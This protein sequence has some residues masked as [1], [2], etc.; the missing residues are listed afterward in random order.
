MVNHSHDRA[1]N[2]QLA[3]VVESFARAGSQRHV[4][5]ILKGIQLFR[6]D[7]N[8]TLF[9]ISPP[10]NISQTFL[11]EISKASINLAVVPYVYSRHGGKTLYARVYNW[12]SRH[13]REKRLNRVLYEQLK[14]FPSLVCVQPFVADL[15]LPNLQPYQRLCFHL[16][17]HR[18][19]RPDHRH[20]KLLQHS[21]V[22]TVFQHCSQISQLPVSVNMLQTLT[23]PLRLCPDHFPESAETPVQP[24]GRLRI[25]HYSR[26]SP[27]RLIDKVIDAFALLHQQAPASLRIAG[28]IED[29]A[30]HQSLLAQI[31]RLGLSEVVSFV[32]P[33]PVPAED[34]AKMEVDLVWMISLSGHI[35]YAGLEAMAAGLPTLF[36]EVDSL[37]ANHSSDPELTGLIC[38]TPQQLVERSRQLHA[39]PSAFKQQQA[40]LVRRR[41][42]TTKQSIDDLTAFYLG[43][44]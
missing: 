17:E 31:D 26:I 12:L 2:H 6:P 40:Q 35:G 21:R 5:E 29:P 43:Q 28:F 30:Y 11:P 15:L 25:A 7:L 9:L 32:D 10:G 13:W 33:V 27:M 37:V 18:S 36:L 22:Y 39:D 38:T 20:Y 23:W 1:S 41:F 42:M 24:S 34:P 44:S 8:C 16:S 14:A 3:F 4:L 19:Q